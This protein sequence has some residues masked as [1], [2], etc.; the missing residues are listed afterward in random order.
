MSEVRYRYVPID[1]V[2]LPP[3]LSW[4]TTVTLHN[5]PAWNPSLRKPCHNPVPRSNTPSTVP[6]RPAIVLSIVQLISAR[7]PLNRPTAVGSAE[8]EKE[9][10][11]MISSRA[12][13]EDR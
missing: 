7:G 10:V 4:Y 6:N 12:V 2:P 5:A 3:F 13:L 9:Q 8:L 11:G 1:L